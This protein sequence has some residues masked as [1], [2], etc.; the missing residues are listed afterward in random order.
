MFDFRWRRWVARVLE[1]KADEDI[2]QAELD[3]VRGQSGSP[4]LWLLGKTQSGKSSIIQGLTGS[5]LV[6]I[7]TGSRACTRTSTLYDFPQ[8]Q[9]PLIRFLDTRGIGEPH[10][11]PEEDLAFAERQAHGVLVVMRACDPAQEVIKAVLAR[12]RKRQPWWPIVLVQTTLHEG[13][14]RGQGHPLPYCFDRLT[15]PAEV[16]TDLSRALKYQQ[17]HF[18]GL[19]DRQVAI[20]FTNPEDDYDPRFY[21]EDALWAAIADILPAGFRA[22]LSGR[23]DLTSGFR[24]ILFKTA[25]PHIASYSTL[26]GVAA[27]VPIPGANLPG[28]MFAQ[29][30]MLHSIASIY[31]LPLASGLE[32]MGAAIGTSFLLRSASRSLLAGIPFV[33]AASAGVL[34]AS[35][36]YALGCSLCWYFA[37]I[38]RGAVPTKA[39]IRRVY[40]D[41]LAPGRERFENYFRGRGKEPSREPSANQ[42]NG[43]AS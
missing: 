19:V 37:Q 21:G 38:K 8:G 12:V 9:E 27:A 30:K 17:D 34:T 25:F 13:Y 23:P 31:G 28:V 1:P 35:A 43:H 16:P 6:E 36:T 22:V 4:V 41:Q 2:I 26:A 40:A 10:Y 42:E 15:L 32:A 24:D 20:D 14:P 33:G 18:A 39:Q 3:K 7:G 5:T 11:D 29:T